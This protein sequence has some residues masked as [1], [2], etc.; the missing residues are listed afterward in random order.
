MGLFTSKSFESLECLFWDQVRDLYD[1]EQ[2]IAKALPKMAESATNSELKTS[3]QHHATE[4]AQQIARLEQ[5]FSRHGKDSKRESCEAMKGIIEEGEEIVQ[6]E[7]PPAVKDHALVVAAQRVEHYEIAGYGGARALA[8]RIGFD[9]DA[10][11]LQ[12]TLDEEGETDKTL[13]NIAINVLENVPAHA[14]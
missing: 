14:A 8:H 7:A 9:Q 1:A 6:S 4:T 3:F 13:S 10:E 11:L 2:R 5:I 12:Q